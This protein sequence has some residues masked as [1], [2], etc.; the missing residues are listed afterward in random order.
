MILETPGFVNPG[1]SWLE[2][3]AAIDAAYVRDR[4]TLNARYPS[5]KARRTP[6]ARAAF[7]EV[8]ARYETAMIALDATEGEAA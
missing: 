1:R 8:D 5:L 2:A 4:A 6:E 3:F 7:A